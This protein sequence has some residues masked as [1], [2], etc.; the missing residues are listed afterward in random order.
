MVT[1]SS[2]QVE[3]RIRKRYVPSKIDLQQP[4]ENIYHFSMGWSSISADSYGVWRN[5]RDPSATNT[6]SRS[7]Y[8]DCRVAIS[9]WWR[10]MFQA[11]HWVHDVTAII[12]GQEPLS[13]KMVTRLAVAAEC[14][15][16]LRMDIH[17]SSM[18]SESSTIIRLADLWLYLYHKPMIIDVDKSLH[19]TSRKLRSVQVSLQMYDYQVHY[20]KDQKVLV[21]DIMSLALLPIQGDH[22]NETAN[23]VLKVTWYE[24]LQYKMQHVNVYVYSL[25]KNLSSIVG[26][27]IKD[28]NWT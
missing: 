14:W 17:K 7:V 15:L 25:W 16:L 12:M 2:S 5:W 22:Q 11:Y 26:P 8:L 13:C 6:K 23:S 27:W 21:A 4:R 24:L 3:Q 19:R 18:P 9:V 1:H 28:G 20:Q 10:L